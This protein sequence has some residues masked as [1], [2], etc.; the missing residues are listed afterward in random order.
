MKT[1][2]VERSAE[3]NP[4]L[5]EVIREAIEA[6]PEQRI[7]FA[8][9]MELALY[10]PRLGYY[11]GE[12]ARPGRAGDFL[13]A[14]EAHPIFGH[15]LARQIEQMWDLLGRPASFTLREYGA[16]AGTLALTILEG[17]RADASGLLDAL[18]YEP[19]ERNPTRAA[20]LRQRLD[21]AGF[22]EQVAEPVDESPIVGLVL[23]NEFVDALPVHRL[24]MRDGALHE[25]YVTW[26]RGEG[27]FGEALGSLSTPRIAER[28]AAEGVRL[29]EGQRAEVNLELEAWIVG[30][31]RQL[32]R[33]Y[34][35]VIDYGYPAPELYGP[36]RREGT[37]KAYLRHTV[38]TDPYRAVGEQD[39]TAHVDFTSL[40]RAASTDGLR[41]L[42]LTT[43]ADFLA[44]AGIGDLLV[45]L[46]Q[47]PGTTL[48]QYLAAR[49]AVYYLIDP[50]GMGRFR[51][52]ALGRDVPVEPRLRGLA[53]PAGSL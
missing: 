25:V 51:V 52:L 17:L 5:V 50:G 27:W 45:A 40:E 44:G 37:L 34:V 16:G 20:E 28:L 33:G 8:R 7:T 15:A 47:M 49:N 12:A 4:R 41:S 2:P 38:H 23:A 18:R 53:G 10:H 13:T 26:S 31:A 11:V 42:G 6:A 1:D 32:A 9:F 46:Q 29:A 3:S 14:P 24:E 30:V 21:A 39:L 36:S 43:Q 19:V 22:G 35:L 48:E